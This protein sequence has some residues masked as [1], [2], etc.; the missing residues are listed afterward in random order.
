MFV[1]H[2]ETGIVDID[3]TIR[4]GSGPRTALCYLWVRWFGVLRAFSDSRSSRSRARS[5]HSVG[6]VATHLRP[7]YTGM[8]RPTRRD[9]PGI[10]LDIKLGI[11]PDIQLDIWPGIRLDI[12]PNIRLDIQLD[13]WPDIRLNIQQDIQPDIW[14]DIQPGIWP[15]IRRDTPPDIHGGG[16]GFI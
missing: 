10:W 12:W 4:V 5:S 11:L 15:G 16:S 13:I 9:P 7:T 3:L 8:A 2:N 1:C 14:L 6:W